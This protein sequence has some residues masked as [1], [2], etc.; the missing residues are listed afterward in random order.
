MVSASAMTDVQKTF[1]ILTRHEII[2]E[3]YKQLC[4]DGVCIF[5]CDA[6]LDL[7]QNVVQTTAIAEAYRT[8]LQSFESL[9]LYR[10]T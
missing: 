5:G 2:L 9:D 3:T 10:H 8:F 4:V 1:F 7:E 6:A